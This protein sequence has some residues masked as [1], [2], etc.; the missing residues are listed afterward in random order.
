MLL[1]IK[2]VGTTDLWTN[3][4]IIIGVNL[5]YTKGKAA[6]NVQFEKNN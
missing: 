3:E 1:E 2:Y 5:Q 6:G 4:R